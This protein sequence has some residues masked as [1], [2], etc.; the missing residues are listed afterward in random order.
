[1]RLRGRDLASPCRPNTRPRDT[2]SPANLTPHLN[3]RPRAIRPI[4][5]RAIR[6][7]RRSAIRTP[8]AIGGT[9]AEDEELGLSDSILPVW[10][11]KL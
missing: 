6:P 10:N 7:T 4:R 3:T 5:R 11:V 9:M 2:R 8:P 1:M